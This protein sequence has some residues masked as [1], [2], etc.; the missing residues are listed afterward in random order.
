MLAKSFVKITGTNENLEFSDSLDDSITEF[1]LAKSANEIESLEDFAS[2]D[3]E[4][5]DDKERYQTVYAKIE[6]S[7]AA[8]TAGLHFTDETFAKLKEKGVNVDSGIYTV[9]KAF[10]ELMKL[11]NK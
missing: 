10:D 2:N 4:K 8:P 6:G 9:D 3:V 5:L 11:Y 7:A 1:K